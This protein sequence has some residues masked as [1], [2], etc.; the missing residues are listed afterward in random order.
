METPII[1]TCAYNEDVYEPAE[2]SFLMLDALEEDLEKWMSATMNK[3]MER[4]DL[5]CL[6][7]GCGS[8]IVSTALANFSV[9]SVRIIPHVFA[10]DVNPYACLLTRETARVNNVETKIEP[11]LMDGVSSAFRSSI[12]DVIVCNPPYVP[13]L[14]EE[15]FDLSR[16]SGGNVLEKSWDGGPTGNSFIIPFLKTVPQY[17]S[18]SGALYLLL[19]SWNDPTNLMNTVAGPAGLEGVLVKYRHAGREKLSVWRLTYKKDSV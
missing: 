13:V 6:E 14:P 5:L 10:V 19:S 11:V 4:S 8:G 7:V 1:P 3:N 15:K 18:P 9:N 2:D 17:L 16:T 12:F